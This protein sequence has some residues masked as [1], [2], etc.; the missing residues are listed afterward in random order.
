MKKMDIIDIMQCV[1]FGFCVIAFMVTF[2][3]HTVLALASH[4]WGVAVVMGLITI[5]S[6]A[7]IRSAIEEIKKD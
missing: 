6:V 7:V 2:I 5:S 4:R 1:V 3:C